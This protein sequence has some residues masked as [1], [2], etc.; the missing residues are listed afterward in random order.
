MQK[1][2]VESFG[3]HLDILKVFYGIEVN[4]GGEWNE[5]LH[6]FIRLLGAQIK[7]GHV[8]D[9][10]ESNSKTTIVATFCFELFDS[11]VEDSEC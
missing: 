6:P 8:Q 10:H 1:G 2:C 5:A 9:G 3:G 11:V 7:V 4:E